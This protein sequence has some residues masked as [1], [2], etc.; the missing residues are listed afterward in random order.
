M[1]KSAAAHTV[2]TLHPELFAA[3]EAED[4]GRVDDVWLEVAEDPPTDVAFYEQFIRAMRRAGALDR[5]HELLLL[6]L[7]ELEARKQWDSVLALLRLAAH[8]WPD[9]KPLRPHTAR[10]LRHVYAHIPQLPD[11]IAVCKGLP[12]DRLFA[13]IDELMR[14]LPGE[15]YSHTYWGDGVV[16]EL[17]I[18]HDRVVL[19]FPESEESRRQI[20]L[21]FLT[22]HLSHR[23]A[24]SFTARLVKE[25][26]QLREFAEAQPAEFV[27]LVLADFDGPLKQSELKDML[28]DRLFS[29]DDWTRWWSRARAELRLDPWID[30]DTGRGARAQIALRSQPRSLE[31]EIVEQY[32]AQDATLEQRIG[33]VKELVK[34]LQDGAALAPATLERIGGDLAR[35]VQ[36]ASMPGAE[37][38]CALYLIEMLAARSPF[39][40]QFAAGLPTED[41]VLASITDY[42]ELASVPEPAFATRALRKL[43]ERDGDDGVERAAALLPHAP[44]VLAQA[45]WAV[46]DPEKHIMQAVRAVRE[47]FDRPLENPETFH[48]A[49][50]QITERR[51]P[52]LDDYLPLAPFVFDLLERLNDW[53]ALVRRMGTPPAQAQAARWLIGKVRSLISAGDFAVLAKAVVDMPREQVQELRRVLQLHNVFNE[54]ARGAADRCIRLVRRDL[55]EAEGQNASGANG[56]E[57]K[58]HYATPKGLAR[59]AA[60]LHELNTVVIPANAREIEKARSEGDLR[61]NAGYHGARERHVQLLR[62][63]NYLQEAISR[64]RVI[65][66]EMV[67]TDTISFGTRVEL[68]NLET[69][70]VEPYVLLG[71]WES[72]PDHGIYYYMAPFPA[73]LLGRAA[74]EEFQVRRPDGVEVRYRVEKIENALAGGDWDDDT[75]KPA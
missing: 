50:R 15:V 69:G 37:R 61:E 52:Q 73:Q 68:R 26:E 3:I 11:M 4:L 49:A 35:R 22:K 51:W 55:D 1:K 53:D 7:D 23:P 39:V 42:A 56:A 72:D 48:W 45:I 28:L 12:L 67:K 66:K 5:A 59:A 8:F 16:V 29:E 58:F 43:V 38:L 54:A 25:P 75:V 6:A 33:A 17:D 44:L 63:A 20:T 41:D 70:E 60:E 21:D 24:G 40:A 30:F 57:V 31:D 19:E 32:F 74:G 47:L 62:R 2:P 71:Q 10:A 27:K 34:S 18:P 65:T 9:S 36:A 64:A 13:R 46:I 14:M